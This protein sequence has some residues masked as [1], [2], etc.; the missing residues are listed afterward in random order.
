MGWSDWFKDSSGSGEVKE[1]TE[2]HSD[3]GSTHHTMRTEDDAKSGDKNDHSHIIVNERS[4][5]STK[6]AHAHGIRGGTRK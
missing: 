5:G 6:S 3:G 2:R 4:D 1:K